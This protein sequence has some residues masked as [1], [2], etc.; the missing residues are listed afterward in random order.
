[1]DDPAREPAREPVRDAARPVLGSVPN[2]REAVRQARLADADRS[3][4]VSDLRAAAMARLEI[5]GEALGPV[6]AQVPD[7][8]ALFD[9]GLVAGEQPRFHVDIL[10]FVEMDR[11]C[12]TYRFVQDTRWGRRLILESQNLQA[13]VSA[14]ADY[15]ALRLVERAK[16]LDS[17]QL[18]GTL[19][20][21]AL[22]PSSLAP[23]GLAP[24]GAP[25]SVSSE[26]AMDPP[27]RSPRI[28][29]GLWFLTGLIFGGSALYAAQ[30]FEVFPLR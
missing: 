15:I 10:A 16:A 20:P 8:A 17:D 11:D 18:A 28:A 29:A 5:L 1:M 25:S 9:H 12:R 2:L 3:T 23:S 30:L 7:E 19:A 27:R 22:A 24:S 14:A 4:A 13:I 21:F 6:L 26:P